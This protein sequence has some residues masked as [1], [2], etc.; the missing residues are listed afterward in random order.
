V[1]KHPSKTTNPHPL[2]LVQ[3]EKAWAWVAKAEAYLVGPVNQKW[4]YPM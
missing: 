1:S 4:M 3:A 2:P